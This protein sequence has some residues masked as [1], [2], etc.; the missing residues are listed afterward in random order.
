MIKAK[1]SFFWTPN[2]EGHSSHGD[3]GTI[4]FLR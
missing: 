2:S 4:L 1:L 3:N